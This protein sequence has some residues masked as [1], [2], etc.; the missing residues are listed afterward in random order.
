MRRQ[1]ALLIG[2]SILA[3]AGCGE[4]GDDR[5]VATANDDVL[6]VLEDV[7]RGDGGHCP[8]QPFTTFWRP[9]SHWRKVRPQ[10]GRSSG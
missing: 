10:G 7:A 3:L 8:P 5:Y 6:V 1:S 4:V 2:L 9:P